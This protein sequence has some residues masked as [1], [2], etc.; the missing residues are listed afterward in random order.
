MAAL[1]ALDDALAADLMVAGM[2][3]WK[4]AAAIL[5]TDGPWQSTVLFADAPLGVMYVVASWLPRE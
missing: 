2:G 1:A 4:A 5:A 3:A